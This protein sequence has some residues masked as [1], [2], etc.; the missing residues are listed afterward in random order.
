VGEATAGGKAEHAAKKRQRASLMG[1]DGSMGISERAAQAVLASTMKGGAAL[2]GGR[3]R[4]TCE[5]I[6]A[7]GQSQRRLG[8]TRAPPNGLELTRSADLGS[9]PSF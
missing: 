1:G 2:G 7:P 6:I 3:G 5:A 8:G 9:G 4:G